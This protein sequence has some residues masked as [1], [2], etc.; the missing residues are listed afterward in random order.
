MLETGKFAIGQQNPVI[1]AQ[2]QKAEIFAGMLVGKKQCNRSYWLEILVRG[3]QESHS[4]IN[5][6]LNLKSP[7]FKNIFS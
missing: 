3:K 5:M 1:E 2:S 7:T 6:T 4:K